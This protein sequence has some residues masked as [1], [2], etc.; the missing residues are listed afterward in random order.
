MV[1]IYKYE[2]GLVFTGIIADSKEKAEYYL[3]NKYNSFERVFIGKWDE[4][5]EPIY[6]RKPKYNKSAIVIK[7]LKQVY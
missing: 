2:N 5:D 1:G 6:E 7:E 3:A 4:N